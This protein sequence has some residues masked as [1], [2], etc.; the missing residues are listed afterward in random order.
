MT[1]KLYS[2]TQN[3]EIFEKNI[4]EDDIIS[5]DEIINLQNKI[6]TYCPANY[7]SYNSIARSG[8][9]VQTKYVEVKGESDCNGCDITVNCYPAAVSTVGCSTKDGG[10]GTAFTSAEGDSNCSGKC[11][12]RTW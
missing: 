12:S 7:N 3:F 11:P 5:D 10:C 1:E 2:W 9:S 4:I 8:Y 6:K